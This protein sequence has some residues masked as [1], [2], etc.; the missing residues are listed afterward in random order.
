VFVLTEEYWNAD[1]N[2]YKLTNDGFESLNHHREPQPP[3]RA[4][5]T[6]ESLNHHR[7]ILLLPEALEGNL[8]KNTIVA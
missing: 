2:Q 7:E 4:S 5:T 3:S 6:I 8:Q 1:D